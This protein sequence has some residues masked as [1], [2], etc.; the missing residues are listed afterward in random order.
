MPDAPADLSPVQTLPVATI[1]PGGTNPRKTF[2]RDALLELT[3]SVRTHGVLQPILVRLWPGGLKKPSKDTLYELVAGE[4]RWRAALAAGLEEIPALIRRLDDA[5]VLEIQVI[6]NLQRADLHPLEE[7]A[8]YERLLRPELGGGYDV[9]RIA[10]RVGRSVSYIYDRL[11]LLRLTPEAQELFRSGQITAG[12]AIILSRLK[13]ED[14]ARACSDSREGGLWASQAILLP[15]DVQHRPGP[16]LPAE[17]FRKP[18]SVRELQDWVDRTVKL[19]LEDEA[20]PMLFPATVETLKQAEVVEEKVVQITHEYHVQPTARDG[21]RI[22]GPRSWRR[23]TTKPCRHQVVGVVV[24]GAER[25]QSFSVCTAKKACK[26]HWGAEIRAAKRLEAGSLTASGSVL[27]REKD[28]QQRE[29][30][31]YAAEQK[32]RNDFAAARDKIVRAVASAVMLAPATSSRGVLGQILLDGVGDDG[33]G[34]L[35]SGLVPV[36]DTVT[37]LI[38]HLAFAELV[39]EALRWDAH[40]RFPAKMRLLG[41]DIAGFIPKPEATVS[42]DPAKKKGRGATSTK[43]AKERKA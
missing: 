30:E 2:D 32:K 16:E 8:G 7:A 35:K 15:P 37:G 23:A 9:A 19:D 5:D 22:L 28:R 34:W 33:Y 39:N 38:R 17:A 43:T 18:R 40:D 27:K 25:G 36:G 6:E 12:H 31:K 20:A 42:P 24:V 21:S 11:R 13:A 10:E 14:Q 29:A 26:V 3:E 1:N 41:L 4:R